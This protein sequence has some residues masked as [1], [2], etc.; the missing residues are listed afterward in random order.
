MFDRIFG[1]IRHPGQGEWTAKKITAVVLFGAIILV[2]ALFGVA[3]NDRYGMGTGGGTAAVV[4]DT[5]ISVAEFK[6]QADMMARN[7]RL[8]LD[9]L[10]AEQRDMYTKEIQRRTIE[11]MIAY[12]V[13]YQNANKQG[14]WASNSQVADEIKKIPDF[15]DK[16]KFDRQRYD[17]LLA[18][19]GLSTDDFEHRIR[20][21]IVMRRIQG[22]FQNAVMPSGLEIDQIAQLHAKQANIRFVELS[23]AKLASEKSVSDAEASAFAKDPAHADDI[24][25]YYEQHALDYNLPERARARH[26]LLLVDEKHPDKEV[27]EKIKAIKAGL[28]PANFA[29]IA[30][31]ESQDPGSA[32]KGG[33]L[34]FF[35]KGRMV[36]EFEDVAFNKLKPGQISE[37]FKSQFGY[38]IIFLEEHQTARTVGM[39]EAK[40]EIA[41]KL[42]AQKKAPEVM[43]EFKKAVETGKMSD[44]EA[45]MKKT[46]LT[47]AKA[48]GVSFASP[49]VQGIREPQDV[50]QT[51]AKRAG[52]TGL[53]NAIVGA[54]E[55]QY[56]LE[57]SSWKDAEK[58]PSKDELAKSLAYQESSDSFESWIKDAEAK[59]SVTRNPRIFER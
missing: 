20:K 26:I 17:V 40:P 42:A 51:M 50:L 41:R 19:N 33:D 5:S 37:P 49:Q 57:I 1:K 22:L 21:G 34:G 45:V 52:K 55:P 11:Q 47:W 10:P 46:G 58:P 14:I 12:E 24:K 28:T 18:Q 3:N 35:E 4:N 32:K 25:K 36:P 13:V 7:T 16:G 59:T 31:K 39:I 38:H 43:A 23:Q 2:F 54:H 44:V 9:K 30:E 8:P 56:I 27:A 53:V 48:D 15:Q 6:Q 29:K